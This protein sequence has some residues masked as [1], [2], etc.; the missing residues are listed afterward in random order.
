MSLLAV[1]PIIVLVHGQRSA[2]PK[3]LIATK[4]KQYNA[5]YLKKDKAGIES[6]IQ[7][8]LASKFTY[9]SYHKTKYSREGFRMSVLQ[10]MENT[11]KIISA[12]LVVRSV[13]LKGDEAAAI[14]ATTFKGNVNIDGKRFTLTNQSVESDMWVKTG[15]DW[16]LAKRVQINN[17]M[18]LQPG[19]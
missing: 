19:D 12:T 10:D 9:T 4:Y 11:T 6:W 16:K 15:K 18:Q 17:D 1:L 5:A 14:I 2:G 8:S 3:D 13:D 7:G